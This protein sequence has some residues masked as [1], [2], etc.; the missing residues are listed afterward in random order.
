MK[1]CRTVVLC[2]E[3]RFRP[4][5]SY[6]L[7]FEYLYTKNFI[8]HEV[9]SKNPYCGHERNFLLVMCSRRTILSICKDISTAGVSMGFPIMKALCGDE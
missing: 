2:C 1:V 9:K 8:F 6:M 7:M 4:L 3:C 5:L